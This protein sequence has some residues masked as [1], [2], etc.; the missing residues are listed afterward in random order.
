MRTCR[1]ELLMQPDAILES[2]LYVT[3]VAAAEAFYGDVLGLERISRVEGRHVFFRCG[4]GVVL[5]FDAEATRAAPVGVRMTP[6]AYNGVRP[7]YMHVVL[8]AVTAEPR[9]P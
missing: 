3:D 2:A 4:S 8:A 1:D 7:L 9:A 6:P 5:L